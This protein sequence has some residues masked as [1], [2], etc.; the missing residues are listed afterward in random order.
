VEAAAKSRGD[1]QRNVPG[2]PEHTQ[3][4]TS[5]PSPQS[6]PSQNQQTGASHGRV[7]ELPDHGLPPPFYHDYFACR[8]NLSEQTVVLN[9]PVLRQNNLLL[10]NKELQFWLQHQH[11]LL[12]MQLQVKLPACHH[13]LLNFGILQLNTLVELQVHSTTHLRAVRASVKKITELVNNGLF[14]SQNVTLLMR[15]RK[16][17]NGRRSERRLMLQ[18]AAAECLMLRN[19]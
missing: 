16:P 2:N 18:S 5:Q 8:G 6:Q 13:F 4:S 15:R 17:N 12:P 14:S 19:F 7:E 11:Q 1:S 10:T 9:N 3:S